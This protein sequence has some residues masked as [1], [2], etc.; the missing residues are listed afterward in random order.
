[1]RR[2]EREDVSEKK[3]IHQYESFEHRYDELCKALKVRRYSRIL[4]RPA[5]HAL[6]DPED[7]LQA[8]DGRRILLYRG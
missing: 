6:L 4:D 1:M 2:A 5:D 3:A 8:L 7:D